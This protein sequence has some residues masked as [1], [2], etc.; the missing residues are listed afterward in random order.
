ML[1]IIASQ[2][3]SDPFAGYMTS[4]RSSSAEGASNGSPKAGQ[5]R[6]ASQDGRY[7]Q[8]HAMKD[9]H[10]SVASHHIRRSTNESRTQSLDEGADMVQPTGKHVATLK[11]IAVSSN[12][13]DAPGS[14]TIAMQGHKAFHASMLHRPCT[15]TPSCCLTEAA[16]APGAHLYMGAAL[17]CCI[18]NMRDAVH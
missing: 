3:Q 15:C 11:L 10:G 14:N 16:R 13:F 1:A 6:K 18:H 4:R 7:A 12:V 5:I 8:I 17:H 9:S 2:Q